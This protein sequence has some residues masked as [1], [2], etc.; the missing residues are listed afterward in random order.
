MS[1]MIPDTNIP[2]EI[3]YN[4]KIMIIILSGEIRKLENTCQ[5]NISKEFL[6]IKKFKKPAVD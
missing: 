3:I 6:H 4:E 5:V 2:G 1:L